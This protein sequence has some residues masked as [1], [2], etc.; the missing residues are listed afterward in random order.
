[1]LFHLDGH[2]GSTY[3]FVL[4]RWECVGPTGL[5]IYALSSSINMSSLRLWLSVQSKKRNL[6]TSTKCL[7]NQLARSTHWLSDLDQ[8]PSPHFPHRQQEEQQ[9]QATQAARAPTPGP[10]RCA[11]ARVGHRGS[12]Q[13]PPTAPSRVS[14]LVRLRD[15]Q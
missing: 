4:R 3:R 10:S 6:S 13:S 8:V 5:D 9:R 2:V 15:R 1:M 12:G 7:A 14:L 11:H